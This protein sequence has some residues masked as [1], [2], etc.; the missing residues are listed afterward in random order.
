MGA[1]GSFVFGTWRNIQVNC[2][3]CPRAFASGMRIT[4][5]GRLLATCSKHDVFIV[6]IPI[7]LFLANQTHDMVWL[8]QWRP[9][10]AI[11]TWRMIE[12]SSL[13]LGR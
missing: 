12:T 8:L 9:L 5:M 2:S 10:S 6:P 1:D 7:H 4:S 3:G 11:T 13:P